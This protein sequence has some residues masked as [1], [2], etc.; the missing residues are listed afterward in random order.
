MEKV[1][2][3]GNF[4]ITVIS[5]RLI[6]LEYQEEG[7]FNDLKTSLVINKNC[8]SDKFELQ[9]S[10]SRIVI[11][12]KHFTLYY[13]K[14]YP[15]IG[16]RSNK[17]EF[18]KIEFLDNNLVWYYGFEDDSNLKGSWDNL[19][20]ESALNNGLYSYNG[21]FLLDDSATPI[22][23]ENDLVQKGN[24]NRTDL[25][26]FI[27]G[28]DLGNAFEDYFKITGSGRLLNRYMYG[29]IMEAKEYQGENISL[30]LSN[31]TKEGSNYTLSD[32]F[33]ENAYQI[34]NTLKENGV[35]L[36]LNLDMNKNILPTDFKYETFRKYLSP[37][38]DLSITPE[39]DIRFIKVFSDEYLEKYYEYFDV[40]FNKF[41][42]PN[43]YDRNI[44]NYYIGR[45]LEE[46][47]RA[48][49]VI[50]YNSLLSPHR[51][52]LIYLGSYKL[53]ETFLK[54]L[55][56]KLISGTN[57]GVFS[58]VF[59]LEGEE[60]FLKM[61]YNFLVFYPVFKVNKGVSEELLNIRS[62]LLPYIY[63]EAYNY[64]T[65]NKFL[66][67]PYFYLNPNALKSSLKNNFLLGS[68][69]FIAPIVRVSP[70]KGK[71][72]LNF[73][74]PEGIWYNLKTFKRYQGNIEYKNI[75]EDEDLPA[76]VKRG[77]I[78]PLSLNKGG[79]LPKDMKVLIFPGPTTEYLIYE[80]TVERGIAS[81]FAKTIYQKKVKDDSIELKIEAV[82]GRSGV[83]PKTRN[84][85]LKLINLKGYTK[86]SVFNETKNISFEVLEDKTIL[87]KDVLTMKNLV[88]NIDNPSFEEGAEQIQDETL[89][90]LELLNKKGL[91]QFLTDDSNFIT[92]LKYKTLSKEDKELISYLKKD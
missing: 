9:E 63:T 35:S 43:Y 65:Y 67:T 30:L 26:L 78:L 17:E 18:L 71:D 70:L 28:E 31:L 61:A 38:E 21:F 52:G 25:Y 64:H 36:G 57:I 59:D 32:N 68:N 7:N 85:Y 89:A 82:E 15:F 23:D 72:F 86:I 46:K 91:N 29:A 66:I 60:K 6:R 77:T 45:K 24:I 37:N 55:P 79:S 14:K 39:G 75:F 84:Y 1:I 54:E 88:V 74:L 81:S 53:D 34:K 16:T 50:G 76:F 2:Y 83:L 92:K 69:L 44:L 4:R 5:E 48:F 22:F 20:K 90:Y 49:N 73:I 3:G 12:T 33:L 10:G 19:L 47:G 62:K 41:N 13:E 87:V 56:Y 40:I 8:S 27:Y 51:N 11:K 58:Y 42:K 80:D